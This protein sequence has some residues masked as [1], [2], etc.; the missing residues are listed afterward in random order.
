MDTSQ[1][2][3][4]ID[5]DIDSSEPVTKKTKVDDGSTSYNYESTN[6]TT[7]SDYDTSIFNSNNNTMNNVDSYNSFNIPSVNSNKL[8]EV[9]DYKSMY[10]NGKIY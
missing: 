4:D 10:D 5:I 3:P 9:S 8:K 1:D 7:T 2:V 6:V